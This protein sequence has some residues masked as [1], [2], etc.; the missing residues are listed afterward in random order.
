MI[1]M[2]ATAVSIDD[3]AILLR[4]PSGMGKSDLALRLIDD[5]AHLIA[6]DYVELH[7]VQDQIIVTAP[8]QT[9]GQMEVRG[10]GLICLPIVAERPLLYVCDLVRLEQMERFPQRSYH[11]SV[12][13]RTVP[14]FQLD[15]A[16]ASA[17]ARVKLMV[18]LVL[19]R[20]GISVL[21]EDSPYE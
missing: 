21:Q 10:L 9:A 20:Q 19:Q 3:H 7:P 6:D 13:N 5:G 2:H 14:L 8:A 4:G 15:G 17:V 18:D 16:A 1:R 11:F 12:D